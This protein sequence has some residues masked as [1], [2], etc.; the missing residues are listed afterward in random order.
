M[1]RAG[2]LLRPGGL[3]V[4]PHLQ[5]SR[6]VSGP[7]TG[8]GEAETVFREEPQTRLDHFGVEE[9]SLMPGNFRHGLV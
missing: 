2:N 7:L 9:H 8:L 5:I 4:S 6:L 3:V 1:L